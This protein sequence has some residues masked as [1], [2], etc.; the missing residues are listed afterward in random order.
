MKEKH[1]KSNTFSSL[2]QTQQHTE[3]RSNAAS[4]VAV[5]YFTAVILCRS[6]GLRNEECDEGILR[7]GDTFA[8]TLSGNVS[9]TMAREKD[10]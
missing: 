4:S 1:G 6:G 10:E 5:L 3:N 2:R 9:F 8:S 7:S